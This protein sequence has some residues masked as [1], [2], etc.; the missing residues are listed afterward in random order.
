MFK[1]ALY[2]F[3]TTGQVATT[4]KITHLLYT[5]K[6][7]AFPTQGLLSRVVSSKRLSKFFGSKL[8]LSDKSVEIQ[9]LFRLLG[10]SVRL[11]WEL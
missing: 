10:E 11:R 6:K 5:N 3:L 2:V 9:L 7:V 1:Q 8:L 4:L